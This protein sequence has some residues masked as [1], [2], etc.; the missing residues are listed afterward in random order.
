VIQFLQRDE[1]GPHCERGAGKLA[2][3]IRFSGPIVNAAWA[4]RGLYR[5]GLFQ[6]TKPAI[7]KV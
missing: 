3:E 2:S 1:V 7:L 5:C 6:V 4:E